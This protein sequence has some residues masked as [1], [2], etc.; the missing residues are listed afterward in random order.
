[1]STQ[2][3][4]FRDTLT[5]HTK[6]LKLYVPVVAKVHGGEHPEFHDVRALYEA[7]DKKIEDAGEDKPELEEDFAQ[8]RELTDNYTIPCDVCESYEAVYS[9][10]SDLDQ[11]YHASFP[12]HGNQ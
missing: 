11:S 5:K 7:M 12:S 1:M 9:M 10:L 2:A 3:E 8:L 6:T 4:P